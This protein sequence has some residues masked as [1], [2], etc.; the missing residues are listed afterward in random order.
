[1]DLLTLFVVGRP[2]LVGSPCERPQRKN[3]PAVLP[4]RCPNVRSS[5][6]LQMRGEE[7]SNPSELSAGSEPILNCNDDISLCRN[8]FGA[9]SFGPPVRG[10][11]APQ[12]P[13]RASTEASHA[14]Q[15]RIP[16]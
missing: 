14:Q 7:S 5:N 3:S 12:A 9:S 16:Q 11:A 2:G 13:P 1:D 15:P 8:L 6:Q 10:G 4:D